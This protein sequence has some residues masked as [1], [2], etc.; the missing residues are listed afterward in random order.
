MNA[1]WTVESVVAT[2]GDTQVASGVGL[3]RK[4]P[5]APEPRRAFLP[6][7]YLDASRRSHDYL[8]ADRR[9]RIAYVDEKRRRRYFS[10]RQITRLDP[11]TGRQTPDPHHPHQR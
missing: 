5:F 4:R 7:N 11:D 9:V 10:C 1:T 2:E 3:Y 6:H 8:L